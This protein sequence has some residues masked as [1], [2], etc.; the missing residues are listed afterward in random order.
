V[1]CFFDSRW[2]SYDLEAYR[3]DSFQFRRWLSVEND[4]TDIGWRLEHLNHGI[5]RGRICIEI[6]RAIKNVLYF[7]FLSKA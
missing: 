7:Y 4:Y 2:A 3:F 1:L 6:D 5:D